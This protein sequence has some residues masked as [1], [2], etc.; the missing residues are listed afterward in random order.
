MHG[1]LPRLYR[2]RGSRIQSFAGF[3]SSTGFMT[4]QPLPSYLL[5]LEYLLYITTLATTP[6]LQS[7]CLPIVYFILLASSIALLLTLYQTAKELYIKPVNPTGLILFIP[8]F[9][10]YPSNSIYRRKKRHSPDD[11]L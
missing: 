6:Y 2:I 1:A 10:Y 9:T 11:D 3:T 4:L 7:K 5:L 8:F